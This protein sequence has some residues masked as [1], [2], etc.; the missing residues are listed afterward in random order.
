MPRGLVSG[1]RLAAGLV[2]APGRDTNV[3]SLLKQSLISEHRTNGEISHRIQ[4]EAIAPAIRLIRITWNILPDELRAAGL[5]VP[6]PSVTPSPF[7]V[8]AEYMALNGAMQ[9][10]E[11]RQDFR[12]ASGNVSCPRARL[13]PEA[14]RFSED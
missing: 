9:R 3:S 11:A 12:N 5:M 1:V 8:W 2:R 13:R 10:R 4:R 14:Q 7:V 6:E